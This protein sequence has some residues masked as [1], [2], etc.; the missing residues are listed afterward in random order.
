MDRLGEDDLT[1]AVAALAAQYGRYG[2]R[3]IPALL[4]SAG[5]PVGQDRV[6]RIWPWEGLQVPQKT[7]APQTTLA[8]RSGVLRE[9]QSV[10]QMQPGKI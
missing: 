4:W 7:T 5:W 6:Q 8:E 1:R 9:S 3:R 10:Q 2:W